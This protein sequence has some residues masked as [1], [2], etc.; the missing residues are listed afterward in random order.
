M[1]GVLMM[2]NNDKYRFNISSLTIL[3]ICLTTALTVIVC[4]GYF[5]GVYS[6]TLIN[7]A[8]INVG[9]SVQQTALAV[10]KYLDGY[11]EKLSTISTEIEKSGS[12]AELGERISLIA[13]F[14]QDV[15]AV[16]VYNERGELLVCGSNDQ[17]LKKDIS[18]NL[19]FDEAWLSMMV[20]DYAMSRPHVQN[21]FEENYPW[22]ITIVRCEYKESLAGKVFVAM[23]FS[24]SQIAE[25]VNGVGIGTHG[26][27]YITDFDGNMVYHPRQQMIFSGVAEEKLDDVVNEKDGTYERSDSIKSILSLENTNWRIVGVSYTDELADTRE[28]TVIRVVL[29]SLGCFILV[30]AIIALLFSKIVSQPVKKL[31]QAM[32]DFEASADTYR[33]IPMEGRVREIQILSDSFHHMVDMVQKLM[34]RARQEEITLR[35]T[36]LKALQAQINPHFLYNTLDSIQW[37]CEQGKNEDA[38]KMVNTLALL[39]RISISRGHELITIK[40]E[41][42][43][44]ECYLIIQNYRY[45]NQFSYHL[46]VDE[47]L[48]DCLCSK[49]TLQPLVEN[50][51][52][53][54]IDRMVDEGVITIS[55]QPDGDDILMCVTDNGVGMTEEQCASI[56]SKEKS[57]SSGIGIKNV[58][59]R[60]K[61]H[62]GE[63]YGITVQSE[64]DVGTT[65]TVRIPKVRKEP[66]K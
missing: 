50:A 3:S 47:E 9:Q 39:F 2:N 48:S 12:V 26:Y 25:Y 28:Y 24:F 34:D 63:Q 61:I 52:Y 23:D 55:V 38:A 65:I 53:H 56:L 54:G 21:L 10:N 29:F 30:S 18:D 42:R 45:R 20:G 33:Y 1:T 17:L 66:K 5:I 57:D 31:A 62:F 19:S 35:N 4:M 37:M 8:K 16:M 32:K 46:D 40:D 64:L 44:A 22:V 60:I 51:I 43:H 7:D 14:E 6:R 49:I 58:N 13:S 36:E 27:C 15:E 11:K 59:D 41:L